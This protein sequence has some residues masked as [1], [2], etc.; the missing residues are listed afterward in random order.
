MLSK[1]LYI[2]RKQFPLLLFYAIT[3]HKRQGLSLDTAII[4]L[5]TD[6]CVDGMAMSHVLIYLCINRIDRLRKKFRND[7][8]QIKIHKGKKRKIQVTGII[9]DG[10]PCND[11]LFTYE[12]PSNPDIVRRQ[13]DYVHYPGNEEFQRWCQIL[14]L[15]FLTAARILS[16]SPTPLSD[17]RVPN[18]TLEVP[19]DGNCL[20]FHIS[21][22]GQLLRITNYV[23]QLLVIC[24]TLKKNCLIVQPY[25]HIY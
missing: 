23:M 16:G 20:P 17:E 4:D 24:Q 7:L 19:G 22:L 10:E 2:H 15:K 25:I 21:I 1:N 9:D 13:W 6:V 18:S 12:E 3:I 11:V 5:W 8:P 14:N